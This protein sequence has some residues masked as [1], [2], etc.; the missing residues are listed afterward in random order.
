MFL[1]SMCLCPAATGTLYVWA[2]GSGSHEECIAPALLT[3]AIP[4]HAVPSRPHLWGHCGPASIHGVC[5]FSSLASIILLTWNYQTMCFSFLNLYLLRFPSDPV[6]QTIDQQF[7]WGSAL[8]ISPVVEQGAVELAA[9]MPPG[10]WY[11]LHNVSQMYGVIYPSTS[12]CCEFW[13][14]QLWRCLF[15]L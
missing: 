13:S 6:C 4:L 3:S 5:V 15:S 10:T 1:I 2:K 11:S 8:L 7:L 9:Y 12:F 14:Y